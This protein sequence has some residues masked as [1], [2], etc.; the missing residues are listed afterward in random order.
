MRAKERYIIF[1]IGILLVAAFPALG[2]DE[3][4]AELLP[5]ANEKYTAGD[6]V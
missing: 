2:Q 4:P 5:Q 1:L 6:F 3:N